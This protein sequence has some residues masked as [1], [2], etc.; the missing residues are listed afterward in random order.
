MA[1]KKPVRTNGVSKKKHKLAPYIGNEDWNEVEV[2][3]GLRGS[4]RIKR[5]KSEVEFALS[6]SGVTALV[7]FTTAV[8]ISV[9]A[10]AY[11]M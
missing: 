2:I 11:F 7:A 3:D 10:Y 6:I 4:V 1:D 5:G 8:A 9:G